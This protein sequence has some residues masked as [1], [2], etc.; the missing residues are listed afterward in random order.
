[1]TPTQHTP[2]IV[3]GLGAMGQALAAALRAAA[4]PVTVWNRTPGKGADLVSAGAIAAA[5]PAEA[6]RSAGTVVTVLLD[7]ASVHETLD[8]VAAE[9]AG[10]QWINLT[11]TSPEQSRELARWAQSHDI[12]FLD[13]GIMAVPSM[14]GGPGAA[15]LYSGAE[16]IFDSHRGTLET[17]GSAEY[18]GADPG[19]AALVDFALLSGMYQMFA[20]YFHGAAMVSAAGIG[21]AEF[22]RRAAA[23]LAAMAQGLPEYGRVIDSGDYR[24][25]VQHLAFQKSAMDAITSAGRD[26]GVSSVPLDGI[27]ALIDRQVAAGHG[28]LA[29]ERTIE[30]LR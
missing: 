1:M 3:L 10:R 25:D 20:G 26:V 5:T 13:G 8:P 14:I 19:V 18:L 9:L 11:S 23:W 30:E 12:E 22:G 7:H 6:L 16:H 21:A 15:V 24:T 29:F 28:A 27:A 17:L 4:V 2:V